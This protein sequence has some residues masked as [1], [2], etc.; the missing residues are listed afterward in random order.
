MT[1]RS[2]VSSDTYSLAEFKVECNVQVDLQG[3]HGGEDFTNVV[4][5]IKQIHE[6]VVV[7]RQRFD[8]L[9]FDIRD[10]GQAFDV[11]VGESLYDE[12]DR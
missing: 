4:L 6:S 5:K 1:Q 9:R 2:S 12:L 7:Q 10:R 8:D 11:D 3:I